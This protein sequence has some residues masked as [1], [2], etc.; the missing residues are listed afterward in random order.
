MLT[1][2]LEAVPL[3][4]F[5]GLL[6]DFQL[7]LHLTLSV[8]YSF[9]HAAIRGLLQVAQRRQKS[10]RGSK[11]MV[12]CRTVYGGGLNSSTDG[13]GFAPSYVVA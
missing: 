7:G 9:F 2:P 4:P 6:Q 3:T 11:M 8:R 5:D 13:I 10:F 1:K 12:R